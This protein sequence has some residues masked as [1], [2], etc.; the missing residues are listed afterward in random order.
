ML[1]QDGVV[2]KRGEAVM[3]ICAELRGLR[4]LATLMSFFPRF[5]RDGIYDII[6]RRRQ[7]WTSNTVEFSD[8]VKEHSDRFLA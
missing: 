2:H 7:K 4:W 8:F 5:V 3:R 1:L 6:A